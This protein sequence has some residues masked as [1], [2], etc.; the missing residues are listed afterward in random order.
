MSCALVWAEAA[1]TMRA[2]FDQL[3]QSPSRE[4][5]LQFLRQQ[6]QQM[7]CKILL[8]SRSGAHAFGYANAHQKTQPS[9]SMSL[10]LIKR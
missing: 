10:N 7:Q 1:A 6:Q 3:P 2:V 4:L 9:D 5:L 8:V